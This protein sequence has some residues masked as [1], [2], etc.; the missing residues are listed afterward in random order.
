M[1]IDPAIVNTLFGHRLGSARRARRISQTE[2][3][4]RIGVSRVTIANIERG[5][6]NVQI[7]QAFVLAKALD[8]HPMELIPTEHDVEEA[9]QPTNEDRFVRLAKIQLAEIVKG[10]E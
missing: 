5:G 8:I 4:R 10:A 2:L 6:Q 9:H 1:Q 3:G 7:A